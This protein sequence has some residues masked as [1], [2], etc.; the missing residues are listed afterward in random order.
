[1]LQVIELLAGAGEVVAWEVP[2]FSMP[3]PGQ[4]VSQG[5][6]YFLGEHCQVSRNVSTLRGQNIFCFAFEKT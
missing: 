3:G 2:V 5:A 4:T 6:P 1:M